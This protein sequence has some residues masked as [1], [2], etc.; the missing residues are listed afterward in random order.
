MK[1]ERR[2]T[3]PNPILRRY[4]LRRLVTVIGEVKNIAKTNNEGG[5]LFLDVGCGDGTYI[6]LL[7]DDFDYLIG[8]DISLSNLKVARRQ[9]ESE[10]KR[11]VDFVL[12]DV[13]YLPF[14]FSSIDVVICSEVLEHVYSPV[15]ALRELTRVSRKALLVTVPVSGAIRSLAKILRYHYRLSKIEKHVGH[16]WMRDKVWWMSLISKV[17]REKR[18]KC[19]VRINYLYLSAE[20]FALI[21]STCRNTAILKA[22]DKA[23][24]MLERVLSNPTFANQLIFTLSMT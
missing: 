5:K 19:D 8:L 13:M 2:Y 12:A 3:H 7:K 4:H 6:A 24:G 20:P 16:L 22:I 21:F 14:R 10:G 23:L 9:V 18:A 11:R 17:M 1:V 15:G